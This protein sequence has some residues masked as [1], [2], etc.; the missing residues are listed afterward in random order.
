MNYHLKQSLDKI[1][2]R[3]EIKKNDKILVNSNILK[4][5]SK[6]KNKNLPQNHHQV[7]KK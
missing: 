6:F 7:F 3:L 1:L 4:I 2:N 5:I